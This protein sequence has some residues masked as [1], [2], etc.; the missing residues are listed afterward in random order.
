MNQKSLALLKQRIADRKSSGL[1]VT[2]W[3]EKNNLTKHTLFFFFGFD[4]DIIPL[5]EYN[6]IQ[7]VE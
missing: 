4:V 2:D 7:Q 5:V 6:N 1:N 3:C